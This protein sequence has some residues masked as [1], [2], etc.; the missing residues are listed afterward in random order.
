MGETG[1]G[2]NCRGNQRIISFRYSAA[3]KYPWSIIAEKWI[4]FF[5]IGI[6]KVF[7]MQKWVLTPEEDRA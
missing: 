1:C 3:M 7:L 2:G 5:R 4:F 6:L